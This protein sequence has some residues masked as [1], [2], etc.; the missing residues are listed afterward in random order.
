MINNAGQEFVVLREYSKRIG[1][2]TWPMLVIQFT[3]TGTTKEVY[4]CNAIQGKTKDPYSPSFL[5]IGFLGEHEKPY[6]WKQAKRLWSNMLKRCYDSNYAQGYYGRGYTVERRWLCF[7]N[8]LDDLPNVDDFDN[9]I[10][11]FDKTKPQ[12]NLDKDLKVPGNKVYSRECCA[13]VPEYE[14]KS[15]GARN[16]KPYAKNPKV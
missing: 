3:E 4:K 13:F 5:G 15:A 12:Y 7:A 1:R 16:G 8:F 9:W 6:Y 14:N 10:L 11:G 2:R